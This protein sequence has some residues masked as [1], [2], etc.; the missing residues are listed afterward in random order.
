MSLI[1]IY[2]ITSSGIIF[3]DIV[4]PRLIIS[5]Y[6]KLI[7]VIA[8]CLVSIVITFP[9]YPMIRAIKLADHL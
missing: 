4:C 6:G 9:K 3:L 5:L 7:C 1:D 8:G 2:S